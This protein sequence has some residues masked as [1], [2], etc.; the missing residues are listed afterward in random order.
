[1]SSEGFNNGVRLKPRRF[2]G[3][4]V[5]FGLLWKVLMDRIFPL[6]RHVDTTGIQK[7]TIFGR[8]VFIEI[9][10]LK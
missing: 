10:K 4:P 9:I 8:A 2:Y 5:G 6:E 1:M 3:E 7:V